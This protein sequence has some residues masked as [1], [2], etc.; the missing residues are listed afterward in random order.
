MG[1]KIFW[2][3]M[4]GLVAFY[5][6]KWASNFPKIWLNASIW[7]FICENG[8]TGE[9]EIY[10]IGQ[11]AAMSYE[12][13]SESNWTSDHHHK[14][15]PRKILKVIFYAKTRRFG[16]LSIIFMKFRSCGHLLNPF[17]CVHFFIIEFIKVLCI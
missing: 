6:S 17:R 8:F 11:I 7:N 3:V 16:H 14:N 15:N 9:N 5:Q 10:P 12:Q 2:P 4:F 1:E 13:R